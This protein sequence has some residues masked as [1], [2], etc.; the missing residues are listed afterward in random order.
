MGGGD[1]VAL[2]AVPDALLAVGDNETAATSDFDDRADEIVE[3]D[4]VLSGVED[5]IFSH[6]GLLRARSATPGN[7][8]SAGHMICDTGREKG[9]E[10]GAAFSDPS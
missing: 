10:K 7:C 2:A 3:T 9:F 5:A 1:D 8:G 6:S 4:F